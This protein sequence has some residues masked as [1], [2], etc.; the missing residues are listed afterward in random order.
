M[1][2]CGS[3]STESQH[4]Q[5]KGSQRDA[6]LWVD[7]VFDLICFRALDP[8]RP[9]ARL[10]NLFPSQSFSDTEL[11][12]DSRI[13]DYVSVVRFVTAFLM[14]IQVY[15]TTPVVHE[16]SRMTRTMLQS[17]GYCPQF[18]SLHFTDSDLGECCEWETAGRSSMTPSH[19]TGVPKPSMQVRCSTLHCGPT[20]GHGS[21]VV[22]L[23]AVARD[24]RWSSGSQV[25][26]S[27]ADD[28]K[29]HGKFAAELICINVFARVLISSSPSCLVL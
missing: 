10:R 4:V 18:P 1:S 16:G 14:Q 25:S 28:V 17:F 7:Y 9:S 8:L 19:H 24:T 13:E 23:E 26:C 6:R 3:L 11:G 21:Q 22:A 15:V 5:I 2:V 12:T 27:C 29:P 20:V